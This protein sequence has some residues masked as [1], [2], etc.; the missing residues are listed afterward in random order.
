MLNGSL[1]IGE[2]VAFNALVVLANA[3][4]QILLSMWDQLQISHV[5]LGRMNDIF[6][7]EP[8][9][10]EDHSGLRAVT[11]LEGRIRLERH[12]LP[13]RRAGRAADPRGHRPSTSSRAR[14]WR[15]SAAA[16][17]ARRR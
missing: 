15:S 3:P 5:L 10:G 9:Q 16:G 14:R 1:T 8:E 7:Q 17:R 12:G 13:L 4:L 6:E 2:L 11:T